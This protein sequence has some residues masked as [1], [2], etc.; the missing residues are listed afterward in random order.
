MMMSDEEKWDM[1]VVGMLMLRRG[2]YYN[3]LFSLI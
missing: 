3:L 2:H 1:K